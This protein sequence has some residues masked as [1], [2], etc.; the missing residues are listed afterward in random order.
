[1]RE[2]ERI[3]E[4][5]QRAFEGEAWPGPALLEV[6]KGVTAEQAAAKPLATAHSVWEIVLHLTATYHLVIQR[7]HSQVDPVEIEIP[8]CLYLFWA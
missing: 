3:D 8:D 7:L 5:L 4:Q 1:M 6:L 2:I